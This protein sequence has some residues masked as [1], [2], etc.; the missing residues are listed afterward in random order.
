MRRHGRSDRNWELLGVLAE[1]DQVPAQRV[2][3][4]TFFFFQQQYLALSPLYIITI[5]RHII[6][7][8]LVPLQTARTNVPQDCSMAASSNEQSFP[9]FPDLSQE[10]RD[11]IWNEAANIPRYIDIWWIPIKVHTHEG[12]PCYMES[13]KS[14]TK[15]PGIFGA[16]KA[17]LRAAVRNYNF[18]VLTFTCIHG[19]FPHPQ[20]LPLIHFNMRVDILCAMG[21]NRKLNDM[22]I[23]L[24]M[25]P[26]R[27]IAINSATISPCW[28]INNPWAA[29]F[30][31]IIFYN[32][33]H[34]LDERHFITSR[35]NFQLDFVD[36]DVEDTDT[37]TKN[38]F[39]KLK[40][41]VVFARGCFW[42]FSLVYGV[43]TFNGPWHTVSETWAGNNAEPRIS[44]KRI[45]VNGVEL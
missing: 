8:R 6:G 1:S 4:P 37:G 38:L 44:M 26:C 36:I 9:R 40:A 27:K 42:P 32:T 33:E 21:G 31:D 3:V 24:G 35:A 19:H 5:N 17:S 20:P 15:R 2:L 45:V 41:G 43:H 30:T 29:R 14:S 39:Q 25:L 28:T 12:T 22:E 7:V 34:Q 18:V 16:C 23:L 11:M 13:F 10:I